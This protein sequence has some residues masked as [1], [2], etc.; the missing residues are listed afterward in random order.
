MKQVSSLVVA[1]LWLCSSASAIIPKKSWPEIGYDLVNKKKKPTENGVTSARKASSPS[2]VSK[3][4]VGVG[5]ATALATV[6]GKAL[7]GE[8][9]PDLAL[10]DALRKP[11]KV[12]TPPAQQISTDGASI[13]NEVFNLVKGIVGVGVLSLPAGVAAFGNAPSAIIPATILITVI[14]ILSGFG[15]FLIGK[16]CAYTGAKSYREAWAKSVGEGSSWIP[17]WSVTFKTFFACLAFSMVLADTFSSLFESSRNPTLLVTTGCVLLP[18]CLKKD[19]RSLA[20]FSLLGVIG[21]A[22]T[23]VA[24]TIRFLDGSYGAEGALAEQVA[25]VLRPKFGNL[26]AA[27]VFTPNALTLI[28]MLS[29]AYM[30]HFNAPKFYL[31]LKNNTLPRFNQV[32][33]YGFGLSIFLMGFITMVGFLTF[34]GASNGL[35]LNNYASGDVLM[36]LSRIA[37]AVSLVFSYPLAF[38]GCRDG[39][40]D[41]AKVPMEKRTPATTNFVTLAVL[42]FIT[43][44]ACKL[45]D[46]T[47]VLSFGGATLGNALTYV[48]PAMMYSAIVKKQGRQGEG[49]AVTSS[50][51]SAIVGVVMGACGTAIALKQLKN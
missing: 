2:G 43:Y 7:A 14:G 30:A 9:R 38:T 23:A 12:V 21:M 3:A 4:F 5:V 28:C 41:L 11:G 13:P 15:F 1:L 49:L 40:M 18:L 44:C 22:Y 42:G 50:I 17:A 10:V 37:V 48:Y 24:M 26:G 31:E 19:L 35:V 47:I 33:S 6:G 16:V 27:S 39:F 8:Q 34:G 29:T 32:V 45:R 46:I 25:S 20:P 51:L 36:G